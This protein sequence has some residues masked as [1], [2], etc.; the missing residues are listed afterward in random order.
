MSVVLQSRWKNCH[1][2][3]PWTDTR[4]S[5]IKSLI[6]STQLISKDLEYREKQF[7]AAFMD[8]SVQLGSLDSS[9]DGHLVSGSDDETT[10]IMGMS[11]GLLKVLAVDD[12][13]C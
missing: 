5:L 12:P 11:N 7:H 13:N 10:R 4:E 8:T 2:R 6:P 9:A 3:C 1:R